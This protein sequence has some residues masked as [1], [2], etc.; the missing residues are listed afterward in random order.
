MSRSAQTHKTSSFRKCTFGRDIARTRRALRVGSI[1]AAAPS[2]LPPALFVSSCQAVPSCGI[3]SDRVVPLLGDG[4]YSWRTRCGPFL[5]SYP[6]IQSLNRIFHTCSMFLTLQTM[7]RG[8][9][10]AGHKGVQRALRQLTTGPEQLVA[11]SEVVK[12]EAAR[13][14]RTSLPE[15]DVAC[16]E[17]EF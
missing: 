2:Q 1:Y 9:L 6:H 3:D 17:V 14:F 10:L 5:K 11:F 15:T 4:Y 16:K 12:E 8:A 13:S 7:A